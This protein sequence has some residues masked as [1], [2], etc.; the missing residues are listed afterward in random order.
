M[1]SAFCRGSLLIEWKSGDELGFLF[2]FDHTL[3]DS[4]LNI[5]LLSITEFE[6]YMSNHESFISCSLYQVYTKI[7]QLVLKLSSRPRKLSIKEP[8][9]SIPNLINS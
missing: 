8:H 1:S 7:M 5:S 4:L 3:C 6:K 9:K 2:S